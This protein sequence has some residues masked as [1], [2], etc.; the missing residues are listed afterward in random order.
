MPYV[1]R[2]I[3]ILTKLT[4]FYLKYTGHNKYVVEL[5]EILIRKTIFYT[6][7]KRIR[8]ENLKYMLKTCFWPPQKSI[9]FS[10]ISECSISMHLHHLDLDSSGKRYL[11]MIKR[12]FA[13]GCDLPY[14]W[15]FHTWYGM[16]SLKFNELWLIVQWIT[17][18]TC[19]IMYENVCRTWV[20]NLP[21]IYLKPPSHFV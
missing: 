17:M 20:C 10:Q 8:C 3:G 7:R 21:I 4:L 6:N 12:K 1:V 13:Y 18:K 5:P 19:L 11:E 9:F 15:H 2:K 14:G 16:F